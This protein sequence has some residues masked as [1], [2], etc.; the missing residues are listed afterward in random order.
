MP[1]RWSAVEVSEAID[2][3]EVLLDQA[4]PTLRGAQKVISGALRIP[5]LPEYLGQSLR[6]LQWGL[7]NEIKARRT[8][9]EVMRD[10]IPSDALRAEKETKKAGTQQSLRL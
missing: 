3:I 7:E 10:K 5:H 8:Q 2:E 9:V 4:E 1:I 6:R